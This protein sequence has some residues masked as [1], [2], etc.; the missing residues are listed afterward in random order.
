MAVVVLIAAGLLG[1]TFVA[2]TRVDPGFSSDGVLSMQ[3]TLP[4]LQYDT[5]AKR[6]AF[7]ESYSRVWQRFRQ[8]PLPV[9]FTLS[10]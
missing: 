8:H 4:Q 1:R 5:E 10:Q 9:L 3:L 6:A 7:M 2:L